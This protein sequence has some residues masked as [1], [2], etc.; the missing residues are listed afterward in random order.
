MCC[1]LRRQIFLGLLTGFLEPLESHRVS[2][3]ID[4]M[5]ACWIAVAC[6][7]LIRH[8]FTGPAWGWY[9]VGW[10]FMGLGIITKGVGFLPALMLIPIVVMKLR[11]RALFRGTLTWRCAL[12]PLAMLTVVAAW[13]IP[14]VLYVNNLGTEEALAYRN[15][16]LFKQTGERYANAWHHHEPWYYYLLE[17][18]PWAWLPLVLALPWAVPAWWRSIK[19]GDARILL[20][21][22]GVILIVLFFSL[23]AGKR[24]VYML[25]TIPLLVLALAPLLP[26]LLPRRGPNWLATVVLV[27]S[28]FAE[29]N[30]LNLVDLMEVMVETVVQ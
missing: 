7:G 11:D 23:S 10:A 24:G 8:F 25:P 17:V 20:P 12:G 1:L 9:F 3:E 27:L 26:G 29:K 19:R 15:N 30:L 6:Y 22:S 16:I 14:M 13:L 18:L 5:V 28:V 2:F 21:L 4:A